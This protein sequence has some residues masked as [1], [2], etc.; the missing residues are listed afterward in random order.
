MR[1]CSE[2]LEEVKTY[3]I[4]KHTRSDQ[5]LITKHTRSDQ[6]L[7]MKHTRSDQYVSLTFFMVLLVVSARQFFTF[8]NTGYI[9]GQVDTNQNIVVI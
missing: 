9:F 4:K 6:Y 7:I 3:L 2:Y 1:V 5:Y 8:S